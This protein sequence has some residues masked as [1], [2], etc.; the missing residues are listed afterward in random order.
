MFSFKAF[1]ASHGYHVCKE[2]SWSNTKLT[3]EVK[4]ESIRLII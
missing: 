4:V 3:D 2:I 1:I